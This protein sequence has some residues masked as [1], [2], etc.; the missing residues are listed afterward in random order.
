M[1][2]Y[3]PKPFRIFGGSI[4]VK[5]DFYNYASKTDLKSVTHVDS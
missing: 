1:S 5:A 2:E 3:F 4:D